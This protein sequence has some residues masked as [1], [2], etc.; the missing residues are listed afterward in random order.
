MEKKYFKP[1][2]LT[3]WSGFIPLFTGIYVASVDL[4]GFLSTVNV[5]NAITG[6][7]PPSIMVTYGLTAIGLRGKDG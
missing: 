3:W 6:N 1:K 5:I 2:S 4:H 7:L